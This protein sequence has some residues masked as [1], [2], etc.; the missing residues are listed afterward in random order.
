[1]I[2]GEPQSAPCSPRPS[3]PF[4]ALALCPPHPDSQCSIIN[5]NTRCSTLN[6]NADARTGSDG[7]YYLQAGAVLIPGQFR[8]SEPSVPGPPAQWIRR[9]TSASAHTRMRIAFR[10]DVAAAGQTRHEPGRDPH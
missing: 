4:F 10:R 1:M 5:I 2:E 3:S 9:L 6:A 7:K 8:A